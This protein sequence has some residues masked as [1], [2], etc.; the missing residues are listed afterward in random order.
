LPM[1]EARGKSLLSGLGRETTEATAGRE[2]IAVAD[3]LREI[4]GAYDLRHEIRGDAQVLAHPPVFESILDNLLKNFADHGDRA[5]TLMIDI[6]PGE[7][8]RI[9]L[10]QQGGCLPDTA[11]LLHLFEPFWTTSAAGLGLGLYQARLQARDQGGD[12]SV[13]TNQKSLEFLLTLPNA[14][15]MEQKTVTDLTV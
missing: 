12:L 7:T 9:G 13:A 4:A 5:Q 8:V 14:A 2:P 15:S 3:T 10:C 11:T 6:V 1:M